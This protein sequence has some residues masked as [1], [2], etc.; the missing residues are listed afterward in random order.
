MI[1][2]EEMKYWV[3]GSL[4]I[5]G[6]MIVLIVCTFLLIL[7]WTARFIFTK[8]CIDYLYTMADMEIPNNQWFLRMNIVTDVLLGNLLVWDVREIYNRMKTKYS[9]MD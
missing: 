1:K 9:S 7:L 5:G 6:S 2:P 3:C 4:D 8:T